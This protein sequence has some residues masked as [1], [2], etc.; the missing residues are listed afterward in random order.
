MDSVLKIKEKIN[1]KM[2]S[3]IILTKLIAFN[4]LRIFK[5]N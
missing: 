4:I 5:F 1:K 3:S 2:D